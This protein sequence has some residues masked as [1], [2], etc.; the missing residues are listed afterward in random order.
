MSNPNNSKNAG[1]TDR[2]SRLHQ[3]MT[4]R[5]TGKVALAVAASGFTAGML[6]MPNHKV[7]T[8]VIHDAPAMEELINQSTPATLESGTKLTAECRHA[9]G[10]IVVSEP[11]AAIYTLYT[12][13]PT[14][15]QATGETHDVSGAWMSTLVECDQ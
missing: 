13:D 1:E 8:T 14:L 2:E 12:I 11:D 4:S 3:I 15:L 6:T 9:D 5:V 10:T 7:E